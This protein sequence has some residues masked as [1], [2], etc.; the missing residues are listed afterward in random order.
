MPEPGKVISKKAEFVSIKIKTQLGS[1]LVQETRL[2]MLFQKVF[3]LKYSKN[4]W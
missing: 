1:I 2:L 3:A 4:F